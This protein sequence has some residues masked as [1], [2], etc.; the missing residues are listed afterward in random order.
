[1]STALGK[2]VW[3]V[4]AADGS[5]CAAAFDALVLPTDA[6]SRTRLGPS[7][8]LLGAAVPHEAELTDTPLALVI[9]ARENAGPLI[10]E[11]E[12]IGPDGERQV[13]GRASQPLAVI[14]RSATGVLVTGLPAAPSEPT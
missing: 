2:L 10:V 12:A 11:C 14:V 4:R 7:P 9:R 3:R 13:Y 5:P 1:M 6:S 8:R